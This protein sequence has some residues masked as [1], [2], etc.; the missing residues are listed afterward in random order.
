M[1]DAVLDR[2]MQASPLVATTLA[3]DLAVFLA[4]LLAWL[5][6]GM[7]KRL[8]HTVFSG[9]V[10]LLE[11]RNRAHGLLLSELGIL[12]F[13]FAW[14]SMSSSWPIAVVN[15]PQVVR[16]VVAIM[17]PLLGLVL[18]LVRFFS[19]FRHSTA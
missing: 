13:G 18:L 15:L 2:G 9:I 11:W 17:W 14:T 10:A 5:D 16:E 19:S 1:D 4:P 8:V 3:C 12:L 7:D 6:T